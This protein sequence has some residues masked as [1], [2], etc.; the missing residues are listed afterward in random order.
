LKL[1]SLKRKEKKHIKNEFKNHIRKL[2]LLKGEFD[3]H[4]GPTMLE[5][6]V[7][8]VACGGYPVYTKSNKMWKMWNYKFFRLVIVPRY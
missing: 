3:A 6:L 1:R 8:A 4:L 2:K 7:S 5:G